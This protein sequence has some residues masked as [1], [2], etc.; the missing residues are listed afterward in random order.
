M[1][2]WIS[3]WP[4]VVLVWTISFRVTYRY[5]LEEP[6]ETETF[7][8]A[9]DFLAKLSNEEPFLQRRKRKPSLFC[10][11][12]NYLACFLFLFAS[13]FVL[14]LTSWTLFHFSF[15]LLTQLLLT[16]SC[17]YVVISLGDGIDYVCFGDHREVHHHSP[18]SFRLL[19]QNQRLH[20]TG[21]YTPET[22][23][24]CNESKHRSFYFSL[25][26]LTLNDRKRVLL[27][28]WV[29]MKCCRSWTWEAVLLLW[30]AQCGVNRCERKPLAVCSSLTLRISHPTLIQ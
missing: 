20:R 22:L 23:Q 7:G 8:E 15:F 21:N 9:V 17:F 10:Y 30:Q 14:L 24:N 26:V 11:A 13:C 18:E 25:L 6:Y 16:S 28:I 2:I 4:L 19:A 5:L 12:L 3:D 1:V 29:V 27:A